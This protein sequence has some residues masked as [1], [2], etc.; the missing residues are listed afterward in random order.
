M[1]MRIVISKAGLAY[2]LLR[3]VKIGRQTR[4]RVRVRGRTKEERKVKRV[5]ARDLKHSLP[6]SNA[7]DPLY[8]GCEYVQCTIFIHLI[9]PA[10]RL[11]G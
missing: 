5:N 6:P 3:I 1:I 7:S 11:P 10:L 4:P 2:V 8:L 9:F